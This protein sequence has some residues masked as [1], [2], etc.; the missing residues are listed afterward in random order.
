METLKLKKELMQV[1]KYLLV[2]MF[3]SLYVIAFSQEPQSYGF[4][5][6]NVESNNNEVKIKGIVLDASS[7]S[8]IPKLQP[9]IT[10]I[11]W[12]NRNEQKIEHSKNYSYSVESG[13]FSFS[14]PPGKYKLISSQLGY[15]EV[16]TNWINLVTNKS[17]VLSFLMKKYDSGG[18]H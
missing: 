17:I 1:V 7:I 12:E 14:L 10:F 4:T 2:A 15:H 13:K 16:E 3:C 5:Y 6:I 11:R 18:F 8:P 9:L